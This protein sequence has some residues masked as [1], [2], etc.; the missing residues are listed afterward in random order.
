[1]SKPYYVLLSGGFGDNLKVYSI[2]YKY[3]NTKFVFVNVPNT[4]NIAKYMHTPNKYIDMITNHN[5]M[6][7][8]QKNTNTSLF[9]FDNVIDYIPDGVKLYHHGDDMDGMST[10]EFDLYQH[11]KHLRPILLHPRATYSQKCLNIY[12]TVSKKRFG[13][14][15]IRWKYPCNWPTCQNYFLNTAHEFIP[16]LAT[17]IKKHNNIVLMFDDWNYIGLFIQLFIDLLTD[18]KHT[19]ISLENIPINNIHELLRI[20]SAIRQ[21]DFIHNYSGFY[22]IV[23]LVLK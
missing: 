5:L 23:E 15:G 20:S 3:P 1:M 4:K 9:N 13:L 16:Q 10:M 14:I 7:I 6:E 21:K 17:F 11:K 12:R 8:G 18:G 22:Q 19:V 2:R